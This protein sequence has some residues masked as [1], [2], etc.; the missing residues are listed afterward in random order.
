M[1]RAEAMIR[2]AIAFLQSSLGKAAVGLF[3]GVLCFC[4]P[5]V[6]GYAVGS[7]ALYYCIHQFRPVAAWIYQDIRED[8]N[9]D[10]TA[11]AQ[12]GGSER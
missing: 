2:T 8:L 1:Q 11:E 9:N 4:F 10:V 12:E 3:G 5:H 7:F 6:P